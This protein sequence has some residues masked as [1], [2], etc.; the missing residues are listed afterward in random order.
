MSARSIHWFRQ[1]LRLTDNPALRRAC[2]LGEVIPVYVLDDIS[3]ASWRMGGASRVW[4]HESLASLNASL[5][6]RLIILRGAADELIPA[7]AQA[8]AVEHVVWNRCYEPWRIKRDKKIKEQLQSEGINVESFN[9]SLLWE[10]WEVSKKDGTPYKVFTPYFRKGCAAAEQPRQPL[11]KP[12]AMRVADYEGVSAALCK[13][14]GQLQL[15]SLEDLEL[16]PK[17]PWHKGFYEHWAIG[18]RAGLKKI[19]EFIDGP[20]AEYKQRRDYPADGLGSR[21]SPHL[22]FGEVSP[23]QVWASAIQAPQMDDET[24]RDHFLSELGWREFSHYLLYHWPHFPDQPFNEKY[25][26]FPWL[27]DEAGFAAWCRGKTGFPIVDAGMRELWQTGFMHNRVRMIVASFLVK[28][29]LIPWQRGEAWFWD[30]LLD[31]DLAANSAS[32]QWTAGCGADAA[33]YFRIFN[34]VTQSEKFDPEGAYISRYC[35]ELAKLPKK[36][37]HKPWTADDDLLKQSGVVLGQDYPHP[38]LDLKATR[39]RALAANKSLSQ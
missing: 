34:P 8:L 27:D 12:R 19:K 33:P 6:G 9:G 37:I 3:S 30:C 2:E 4:L 25:A 23:H 21:L 10:P 1:D 24:N 5:D 17:V 20:M 32:W 11:P 13:T 7:L 15:L 28:N 39:E 35:P 18:E 14:T 29:Q 31:A 36:F 38:I 26:E 22:H 16:L